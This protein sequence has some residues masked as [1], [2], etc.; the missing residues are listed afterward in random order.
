MMLRRL[1][2]DN[3][4]GLTHLD[5][6]LD[7]TTVLIGENNTG[8]TTVLEALHI[9]L[10]RAL[11][12]RGAPFDEYDFHI[13]TPTGDLA[14][15][16]P[17][18]ITLYFEE[19]HADEWPDEIAQTFPGV[20]QTLN[21]DRQSLIF[22]VTT[23][24]EAKG[25]DIVIDWSFLDKDGNTLT[26]RQ[27]R[28]VTDLQQFA[29]VFLLTAIR[30]ATQQFGPKSP[31][32]APFT[33]NLQIPD[34]TRKDIETQIEAINRAVLDSHK[35]FELVKQRLAQTGRLLPL[36]A[37]D[38]VTVE[39]LPARLL[40]VLART[41]V[42][43]AARTG[44]RLPITQHGAGTQSLAVLFLFEA[45]LQSQLSTVYDSLTEP[46]VALEEPESHL[47]PS[48]IRA[49]WP[50]LAQLRGQKIIAT[51]SGDLLASVPLESI[52][53]L[54]RQAGVVKL[55]QVAPNTLD[56]RDRE[57]I[58]YHVR[59]KR[60]SLLF[61]R[62]W[63]LVEGETDFTL[64]PELARLVGEDFDAAGVACVEFAQCGL[65]P[66]INTAK[67][68]GIEWHVLADGDKA[69]SDY[70]TT[71]KKLC[72]TDLPAE[73]VTAL[74][75]VSIERCMWDAGYAAV[76]EMAIAASHKNMVTVSNADPA[77]PAQSIAAAAKSS[78]KPA[79]AYAVLTAAA[80]PTSAGVPSEIATVIKTVVGLAARSA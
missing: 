69:G 64:L 21:D 27:Q 7:E 8:K 78:S 52:R 77:Y 79:L 57:K 25:R 10:S 18:V 15:A 26:V 53:R 31:F 46:L 43:L 41:Q 1:T 54:A 49:L 62:C 72:G 80:A 71:A 13:A 28:L 5:I 36:G 60:G 76:Y 42:K 39:A 66:L 33:K 4:R 9:C 24:Y 70:V 14:N 45:F 58:A 67:D 3:F 37:T 74:S 2:I 17:I 20:I 61:A 23:T 63:L 50:M 35:P 22:R 30:D 40:D 55:F 38:A 73:R 12:R 29:P 44:A 19:T 51:H 34:G 16:P 68:L 11:T 75:A 56:A 32:W 48:A 59:A 47:H 6:G 65:R